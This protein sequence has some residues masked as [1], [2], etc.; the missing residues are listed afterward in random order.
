MYL[1]YYFND[2]NFIYELEDDVFRDTLLETLTMDEKAIIFS[3]IYNNMFNET[4]RENFKEE[5]GIKNS[6]DFEVKPMNAKVKEFI[7]D[8]FDE[9][10]YSIEPEELEKMGFNLEEMFKDVAYSDYKNLGPE[11]PN[12]DAR[13]EYYN[14]RI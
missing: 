10:T 7:D 11:D 2:E 4:E 12:S 14:Q 8:Y 13:R 9:I 6:D 1:T 3:Y 5:Y